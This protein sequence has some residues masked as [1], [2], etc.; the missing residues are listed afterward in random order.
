MM[1]R[2]RHARAYRRSPHI[3]M[4]TAAPAYVTEVAE[5]QLLRQRLRLSPGRAIGVSPQQSTKRAVTSPSDWS[6]LYF[7][8]R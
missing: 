7:F 2:G 6:L 5:R 3:A 8:G 4:P 1:R